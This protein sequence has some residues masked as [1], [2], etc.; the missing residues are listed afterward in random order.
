MFR[1]GYTFPTWKRLTLGLGYGFRYSGQG[2]NDFN[3][4]IGYRAKSGQT[5]SVGYQYS[6]N[7]GY[8]IDNMFTPS[9]HLGFQLKLNKHIKQG[10]EYMENQHRYQPGHFEAGI[11][12]SPSAIPTTWE[13]P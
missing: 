13:W 9:H 4:N 6:E 12:C 2:G 11:L 7:G 5:M 3:I 1:F 8:F 10:A